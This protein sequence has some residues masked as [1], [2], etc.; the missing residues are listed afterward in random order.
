MSSEFL[1]TG[2]FEEERS[3]DA[4]QVQ[5]HFGGRKEAKSGT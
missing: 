4:E 3:G 5:V 1:A 2:N